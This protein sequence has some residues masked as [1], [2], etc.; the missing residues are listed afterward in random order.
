MNLNWGSSTEARIPISL[1]AAARGLTQLSPEA[2]S[3]LMGMMALTAATGGKEMVIEDAVKHAGMGRADGTL[4]LAE[5][6]RAG[7]MHLDRATGALRL[8]RLYS[9]IA[10][11]LARFANGQPDG[12][13]GGEVILFLP[14]AEAS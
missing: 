4:A 12:G 11:G 14:G 9:G 7:I 8:H 3:L 13:N 10:Q 6:I 5:L 2:Q 1:E